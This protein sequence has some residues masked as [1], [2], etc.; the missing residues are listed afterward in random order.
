MDYKDC[1]RFP[2]GLHVEHESNICADYISE[3]KNISSQ[4]MLLAFVEKWKY[5]CPNIIHPD[6]SVDT[7]TALRASQDMQNDYITKKDDV[8][9]TYLNILAPPQLL[10]IMLLAKRYGVPDGV[11]LFQLY[12]HGMIKELADG[13]WLISC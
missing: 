13:T 9:K 10:K 6:L 12:S 4:D 8:S 3:L 1:H 2:S 5:L 7:L 11:V